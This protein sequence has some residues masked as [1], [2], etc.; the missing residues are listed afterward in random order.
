[1][2]AFTAQIG[3]VASQP[4]NV[5]PGYG[6]VAATLLALAVTFTG[7]L[8]IVASQPGNVVPGYVQIVTVGRSMV[9]TYVNG[10]WVFCPVLKWSGTSWITTEVDYYD[11]TLHWV[12]SS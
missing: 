8:G 6:A 4:G 3:T 9:G 5:V 1:M 10:V 7:Q 2:A 12:S 11:A